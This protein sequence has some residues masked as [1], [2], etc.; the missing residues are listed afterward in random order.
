[1]PFFENK[2][3]KIK[4]QKNTAENLCAFPHVLTKSYFSAVLTQ[5]FSSIFL[6][7]LFFPLLHFFDFFEYKIFNI[8]V[9]N[10]AKKSISKLRVQILSNFFEAKRVYFLTFSGGVI[11]HFLTILPS[12]SKIIIW[13]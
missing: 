11:F 7:F 13:V 1:L 4:K 5:I 9:Q 2:T 8:R 3:R 12:F 6:L 10:D